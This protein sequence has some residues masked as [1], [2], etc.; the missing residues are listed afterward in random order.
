MM[1]PG[2]VVRVAGGHTGWLK[3]SRRSLYSVLTD[4]HHS[5][6]L[7]RD[8]IITIWPL[9]DD[10]HPFSSYWSWLL[11]DHH[12]L[13]LG[14]PCSDHLWSLP[15]LSWVIITILI[16]KHTCWIYNLIIT[17]FTRDHRQSQ[18]SSDDECH[19][20][21]AFIFQDPCKDSFLITASSNIIFSCI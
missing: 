15:F 13:S 7:L 16:N 11:G 9:G 6:W 14:G 4:H 3:V 2:V 21:S 1:M 18:A 12:P 8:V 10:H 17:I 20:C 19:F 5:S